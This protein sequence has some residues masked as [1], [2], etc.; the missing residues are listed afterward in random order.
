MTN[1]FLFLILIFFPLALKRI[2]ERGEVGGAEGE[3]LL[4][5]FSFYKKLIFF[6]EKKLWYFYTWQSRIDA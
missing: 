2:R 4:L 6:F 5:F 1:R 3:D